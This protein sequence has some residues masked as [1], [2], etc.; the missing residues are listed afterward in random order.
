ML[1]CLGKAV[2]FKSTDK[3]F[4]WVELSGERFFCK[5]SFRETWWGLK[6]IVRDY[7]ALIDFRLIMRDK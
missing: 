5:F 7:S 4:G 1:F 6:V 2:K 3:S